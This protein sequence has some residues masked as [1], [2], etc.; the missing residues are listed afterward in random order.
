[1]TVFKSASENYTGRRDDHSL[2][3]KLENQFRG[4]RTIKLNLIDFID[5]NNLN[6]IL[7][8]NINDYDLELVNFDELLEDDILLITEDI[9]SEL[10]NIL[11]KGD[12]AYYSTLESV[13][14]YSSFDCSPIELINKFNLRSI[15][16]IKEFINSELDDV[17]YDYC[18]DYFYEGLDVYQYYIIDDED[19]WLKYTDYPIFYHNELDVYIVGITHLGMSWKYFSTSYEVRDYDI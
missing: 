7:C 14:Y 3:S 10:K 16:D 9:E 4:Y 17:I 6:L 18:I 13:L 15:N 5:Y 2:L 19:I 11:V 1:M 12:D 8:N